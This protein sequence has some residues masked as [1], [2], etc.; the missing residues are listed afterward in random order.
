MVAIEQFARAELAAAVCAVACAAFQAR[1]ASVAI[2]DEAAGE[3]V[4]IATSG[5]PEDLV[6]AR[7]RSS[8]G[9]AGRALATRRPI[10]SA[11]TTSDPEFAQE[12]AIATGFEPDSMA[13]V[14]VLVDGRVAA[15]LSL[16]DPASSS[17]SAMLARMTALA[18]HVA[19]G[20]TLAASLDTADPAS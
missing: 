7:F 6:G 14:P 20:F 3:F 15:V 1:A 5:G 11:D 2:L 16:L 18:E 8:K 13:V 10:F 4:F 19:A 9:L 12:I 17:D